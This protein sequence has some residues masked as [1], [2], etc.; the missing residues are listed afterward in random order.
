MHFRMF[1][2]YPLDVSSNLPTNCDTKLEMLPSV[3]WGEPECRGSRRGNRTLTFN[4]F[5]SVGFFRR[6]KGSYDHHH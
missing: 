5:N 6:F 2:L 3:S 1:V 4:I